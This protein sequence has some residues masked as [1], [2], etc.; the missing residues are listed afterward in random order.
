MTKR[1]DTHIRKALELARELTILADE[2]EAVSTDDGCILLYSIIRDCAYKIRDRAG[3]ERE[4]HAR[5][6]LWDAQVA[7]DNSAGTA[8]PV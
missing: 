5:L 7:V 4:Y 2:G 8:H 1:C 3:K 6:D